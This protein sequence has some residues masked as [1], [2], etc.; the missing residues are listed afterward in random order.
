M[1]IT[2][3]G[4]T[5]PI[6]DFDEFIL[7]SELQDNNDF[8]MKLTIPYTKSNEIL[9][10]LPYEDVIIDFDGTD[11][12][13]KIM[14]DGITYDETKMYIRCV[15]AIAEKLSAYMTATYNVADYNPITAV[16]ELL[17]DYNIDY[18]NYAF[19]KAKTFF[20]RINETMDIVFIYEPGNK[21]RLCDFLT[22]IL[23][24]LACVLVIDYKNNEVTIHNFIDTP[25]NST[26]E[27]LN[28]GVGSGLVG[29]YPLNG[30]AN[31]YSGNGYNGAVSGATLAIDRFGNADSCYSFT[32][33][34][35]YIEINHNSVLN[36]TRIVSMSFW[37][38][39]TSF[40][41]E[42]AVVVGKSGIPI[43]ATNVSYLVLVKNTGLVRLA[44]S[45]S[46]G[47]YRYADSATGVI[48]LDTWYH[49][50][51]IF[52]CDTGYFDCY[53]DG[54]RVINSYENKEDI[55]ASTTTL[56]LGSRLASY[57]YIG[58]I[59]DVRIYN[60]ALTT[61]EIAQLYAL[62]SSLHRV[63][64]TEFETNILA[65]S[66][67]D[68]TKVKIDLSKD[69]YNSFTIGV[70]PELWAVMVYDYIYEVEFKQGTINVNERDLTIVGITATLKYAK[71]ETVGGVETYFL[72][73]D[74]GILTG[75]RTVSN[76]YL[77]DA[78]V[79]LGQY[80]SRVL[81]GTPTAPIYSEWKDEKSN[82]D[83]SCVRHTTLEG[84][85]KIGN[86]I[87]Q[88]Y[89]RKRKTLEVTIPKY[90]DRNNGSYISYE[91]VGYVLISQ[92][93]NKDKT[94]TILLEEVL[95]VKQS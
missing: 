62:A 92:S 95:S 29:Y 46:L 22:E 87:V 85:T 83:Y 12:T 37:L 75:T 14:P 81:Y 36:M 57:E 51:A 71:V 18:N 56:F 4:E 93:I 55:Y 30:N 61:T 9:L 41:D 77:D 11:Y 48:S 45:D 86:Y 44:S 58:S 21:M 66:M 53:I 78:T 82:S 3:R 64:Q 69:Y 1:D 25:V 24:R 17:D 50:C 15:H 49:C 70:Y 31:D 16:M 23:K 68:K 72:A 73:G 26:N 74:T 40:K 84:A 67:I 28:V 65:R 52:D 20:T 89:W 39:M 94:A 91:G 38:K 10:R 60:R 2:Y 19:Q 63:N 88:R 27:V 76:S 33:Y 8:E 59:D 13:F 79:Y 35:S 5:I 43:S 34:P 42:Y 32:N 90:I 7:S 6:I 54:N 80:S 47:T